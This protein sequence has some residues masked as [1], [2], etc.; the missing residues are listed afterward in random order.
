MFFIRSININ[1]LIKEENVFT[2]AC[3]A[4]PGMGKAS[5]KS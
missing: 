3:F 5:A 2:A 4:F 1:P